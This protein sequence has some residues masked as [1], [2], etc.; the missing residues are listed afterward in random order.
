MVVT[1]QR[2]ESTVPNFQSGI[3]KYFLPYW[4]S[5]NI[6]KTCWGFYGIF[7]LDN[8]V[9]LFKNYTNYGYILKHTFIQ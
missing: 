7:I 9:N 4:V 3:I 6:T 1:E 5:K 2:K 8:N